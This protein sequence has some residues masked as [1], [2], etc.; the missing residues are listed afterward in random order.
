[1]ILQNSQLV[2]VR[3]VL[4]EQ[5]THF[6]FVLKLCLTV[7]LLEHSYLFF[8]FILVVNNKNN[9]SINNNEWE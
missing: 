3:D 6:S 7:V 1:M 4:Q 5:T 9:L 8:F 2:F